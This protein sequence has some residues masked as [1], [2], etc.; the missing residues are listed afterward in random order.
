MITEAK[1]ESEHPPGIVLCGPARSFVSSGSGWVLVI[2][3]AW[4]LRDGVL[5]VGFFL[6]SLG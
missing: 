2:E 1:Q 3:T 5:H 4:H 6:L